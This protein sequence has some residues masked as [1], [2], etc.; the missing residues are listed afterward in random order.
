MSSQLAIATF[1]TFS[2]SNGNHQTTLNSLSL[3]VFVFGNY[4]RAEQIAVR[5]DVQGF[6]SPADRQKA[7]LNGIPLGLGEHTALGELVNGLEQG[8]H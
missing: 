4:V 7:V 6:S 1:A 8:V 2:N 5:Q 3:S